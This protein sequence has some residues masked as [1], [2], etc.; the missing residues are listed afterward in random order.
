MSNPT[1]YPRVYTYRFLEKMR[2]I[3]GDESGMIL[4]PAGEFKVGQST[5]SIYLEAYYIDKTEV[6]Q[7]DFKKEMGP[8]KFFF[9]RENHPAEQI[10]WYKAN[11][12]CQ[13]TGKRLPTEMEWEKAAKG[14]TTTKYFGVWNPM[15]ITD[16]MEEITT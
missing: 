15:L 12:Y 13:K 5:K 7:K 11:D 2:Y 1:K 3:H 16:G 6:T 8:T 4:I 9:K 14:G 10:N